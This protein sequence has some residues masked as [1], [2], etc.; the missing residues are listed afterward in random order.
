M[1]QRTISTN[2]TSASLVIHDAYAAQFVDVRECQST[3]L[4]DGSLRHFAFSDRLRFT[5]FLYISIHCIYT[6]CAKILMHSFGFP[7]T[8]H[9]C[10]CMLNGPFRH[11]MYYK[12]TIF[13]SFIRRIYCIKITSL[14]YWCTIH[15]LQTNK[16]IKT[17]FTHDWVLRFDVYL[18]ALYVVYTNFV[19]GLVLQWLIYVYPYTCIWNIICG[20]YANCT[21]WLIDILFKLQ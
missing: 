15:E 19:H 12:W 13:M 7:R 5:K 10:P 16:A 4:A 3:G 14:I 1:P 6:H 18:R 8:F 9:V 20:T 17:R 21:S 2:S 11:Y